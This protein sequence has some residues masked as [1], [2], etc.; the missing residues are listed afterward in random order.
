[1]VLLRSILF[2]LCFYALMIL[3]MILG[4][5]VLFA[6]RRAIEDH[7]RLW[8]RLSLSLLEHVCH[9]RVEFRGL[10]NLPEGATII[11]AKHQ[12]FLDV[13]ALILRARDF[14]FV[15][16]RELGFI[17]LFGL[18]LRNSEQ[19]A[20]DRAKRGSALPQIIA[21]AKGI[22]AARRQLL[23]FPEGTRR[24]VGAPPRYKS[25]VARIAQ[26]TGIVCVPVALNS[27]LFWR[28]RGF[29]RRP[30]TAVIE[31]LSPIEAGPDRDQ[32]M[33]ALENRIE[34][35]SGR[36]LAEALAKDPSLAAGTGL[37]A[38]PA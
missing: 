10:E 12:S 24:P 29:M 19:I 26:E 6:G 30:G 36:L 15:Y 9:L 27:G 22:F 7:A 32:F 34:T 16:K 38:T 5:P 25:G 11:A 35:A 20:I 17:P 8:A 4:L 37:S 13:L 2:N 3:L 28:R 14:A 21:A 31:F 1:M 23:I 33:Q 18:Y